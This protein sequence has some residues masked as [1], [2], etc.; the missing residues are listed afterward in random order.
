M[1]EVYFNK[2]AIGIVDDNWIEFLKGR[3]RESPLRRSRLCVHRS[4]D[5]RVHEM[6]IVLCKDVLFRPHR[7][8]EKSESLHVIEGQFYIVFF[9]EEG[10]PD[11]VIHMGAIGTGKVF[12]YR[13][14]EPRWHALVP[15]SDM[16]VMHETTTGPFIQGD[17]PFAP[18]A[19]QDTASLR[20]FLE[21]SVST[22]YRRAGGYAQGALPNP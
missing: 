22:A 4:L 15:I 20:D 14:C 18:W 17:A 9:D 6:I 10:T 3:A 5:E 19:P 11:Q 7:H 1:S 21:K 8:L 12:Y 13:L 16:I 2:D